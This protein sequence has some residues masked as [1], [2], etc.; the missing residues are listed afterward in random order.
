MAL[1]DELPLLRQVLH[2]ATEDR[3]K[4]AAALADRIGDDVG[5]DDAETAVRRAHGDIDQDPTRDPRL[6]AVESQVATPDDV[7]HVRE[8]KS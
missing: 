6:R 7:K 1:K 5:D 8:E 4:E 2:A 3:K